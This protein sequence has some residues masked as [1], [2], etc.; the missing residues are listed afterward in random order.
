M[1]CSGS[2]GDR[3]SLAGSRVLALAYNDLE[4]LH[5]FGSCIRLAAGSARRRA[6]LRRKEGESDI[7]DRW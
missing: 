5:P 3:G 2:F 6:V 7:W 1:N 4:W